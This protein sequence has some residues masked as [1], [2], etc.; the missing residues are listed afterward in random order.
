MLVLNGVWLDRHVK[1]YEKIF[2]EIKLP[3]KEE[4]EKPKVEA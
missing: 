4:K 2:G 1:E 3:P